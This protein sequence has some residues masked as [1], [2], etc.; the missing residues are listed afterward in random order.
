MKNHKESQPFSAAVAPIL[1]AFTL[2]TIAL[3][4]T[5]SF[6]FPGKDLVLA[7]FVASTGVLLAGFQFAVGR[8]SDAGRVWD[9]ARAILT[10][11]GLILLSAA[12]VLLLWPW[13]LSWPGT[14]TTKREVLGAGLALLAAGILIPMA[15]KIYL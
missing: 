15:L 7:L 8:F 2:P 1:V 13:T 12:L 6:R 11:L 5:G 14:A 9:G 3:I 10:N 4:V